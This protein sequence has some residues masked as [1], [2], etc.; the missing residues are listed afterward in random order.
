VGPVAWRDPAHGA[1]APLVVVDV[2]AEDPLEMSPAEDEGVVQALPS[3]RADPSLGHGVR[4]WG[5]DGSLQHARPDG[6][7]AARWRS[8]GST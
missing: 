8:S 6:Y 1:G 4:P 7:I 2:G 5:S 3:D